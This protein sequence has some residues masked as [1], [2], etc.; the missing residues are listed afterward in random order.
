MA[1]VVNYMTSN[2]I[3]LVGWRNSYF[4]CGGLGVVTSLVGLVFMREP[5][6]SVK[7]LAEKEALIDLKNG[8][9]NKNES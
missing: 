5:L 8:I 7:I 9:F 1:D 2:F 3:T 6:N 4:I